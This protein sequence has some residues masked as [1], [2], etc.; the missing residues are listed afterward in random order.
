MKSIVTAEGPRKKL[1]FE[2]YFEQ[3]YQ[4]LVYYLMKKVSFV[5][6]AE[7]LAME[8]FTICLQKFDSFDP[9]RATFGTWL[10]VIANNKLKNYYRDHKVF[11]EIDDTF[12]IQESF[13]DAVLAAEYRSSMREV[14]YNALVSLPEVQRK[15]VIY[16]YARKKNSNEIGLLLGLT[17]GNVRQQLARAIAKL[18]LYFDRHNF[19]WES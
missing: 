8:A 12:S 10:Y 3:Y 7:D 18:R 19:R 16:T 13:E 6:T 9:A 1:S 2:E 11:E 4:K 14:L 17:P 15:I 5:Q